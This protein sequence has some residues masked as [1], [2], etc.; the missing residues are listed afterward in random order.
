MLPGVL[1]DGSDGEAAVA[2]AIV[3]GETL[4]VDHD[5]V[6]GGGIEVSALGVL[7]AGVGGECSGLGA[8]SELDALGR[9][10]GID[11]FEVEVLVTVELAEL[12]AQA[13]QR[14]GPLR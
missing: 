4:G 12:F 1:G 2:A 5:S 6:R 7:D 14:R 8:A 9:G 11:V 3:A 10:Q 13:G